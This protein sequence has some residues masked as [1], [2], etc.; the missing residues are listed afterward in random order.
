MRLSASVIVPS[1]SLSRY[2]LTSSTSIWSLKVPE[3]FNTRLNTRTLSPSA[4][5]VRSRTASLPWLKVT[6]CRPGSEAPSE[7]VMLKLRCAL[8]SGCATHGGRRQTCWG[9]RPPTVRAGPAGC[10]RRRWPGGYPPGSFGSRRKC[11]HDH[12]N[13]HIQ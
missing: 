11:R 1:P 9:C 8:R 6:V 10:R 5:A 13:E 12:V 4:M 7:R 2:M 3:A